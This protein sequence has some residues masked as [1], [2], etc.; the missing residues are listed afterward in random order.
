MTRSEDSTISAPMAA[1]VAWLIVGVT[2]VAMFGW[3][4]RGASSV[5]DMFAHA[6]FDFG[7]FAACGLLSGTLVWAW[8][9]WLPTSPLAVFAAV[10]A[11]SLAVG[12]VTLTTDLAHM[13]QRLSGRIR[14]D[15]ILAVS[16]VLVSF[17]VPVAMAAGRVLGRHGL[18]AIGLWAAIAGQVANYFILSSDYPAAHL[19]L[20]GA[21]VALIA[22]SLAGT[23][24]P[25]LVLSVKERIPPLALRAGAA[26][27]L[28]LAVGALLVSPSPLTAAR[29]TQNSGS[30]LTPYLSKL[31]PRTR[32]GGRIA[33][34]VDPQWFQPRV[35]LPA[36]P[37]GRALVGDDAVVLLIGVD[38]LRADVVNSGQYDAQLPTLAKLRAESVAFVNARANG[39]QTVYSLT[40]LFA[41]TYF[42]QQYWSP[43]R[44]KRSYWPDKDPTPRFP[45]VLTEAGVRTI[46]FTGAKWMRNHWGVVSGFGEEHW[47]KDRGYKYSRAGVVAAAIDETLAAL[48]SGPAFIFVHF[49]DP[50]A[51]YNMVTREGSSFERYLAECAQVD[52]A[53]GGLLETIDSNEA[54]RAR[55]TVIVT[56]DHGEAFGEHRS[57]YHSRTLYDELLRVPL[58]VRVPGAAPRVVDTPVSLVDLGPT[59]LDLFQQPTPAHNMG[60]TLLP[61]VRG[62]PYAPTRPFIAEGRLK[63]AMI[64]GNGIKIIEDT[65]KG[66][67]EIYD[68]NADPAEVENLVNDAQRTDVSLNTLRKFFDTHRLR[69]PGYEAP[70]RP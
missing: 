65:R 20:G 55:T 30:F 38:A 59:V 7:Y 66:V 8:R 40:T 12:S 24:W 43:I 25:K 33:E 18:R 48:D 34:D 44:P 69:R 32:V 13:S 11:L 26:L 45:A 62:E 23:P 63:R 41:G 46:N 47:I 1:L 42:S 19:Y 53:I 29:L 21:S 27:L 60:Q 9:R 31:H 22:G 16:V 51:P 50:H 68:L 2:D 5:S 39:S 52:E 36:I 49:L 61:F 64:L 56:S 3:V 54:L 15:A 67:V 70:Y 6:S 35:D 14:P 57:F 17:G 4:S 28:G 58:L 10:A 37:P